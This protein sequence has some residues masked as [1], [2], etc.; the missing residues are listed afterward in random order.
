MT[1]NL[2]PEIVQELKRVWSNIDPDNYEYNPTEYINFHDMFIY[3]RSDMFEKYKIFIG[4]YKNDVEDGRSYWE[5]G[6]Y[7]E[8]TG[9][10]AIYNDKSHDVEDCIYDVK[11]IKNNP[12]KKKRV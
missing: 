7:D 6:L 2:K 12:H 9:M 10:V 11:W 3:V 4:M 8:E 5:L 1:L